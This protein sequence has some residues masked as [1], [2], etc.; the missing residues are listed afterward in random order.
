MWNCLLN[1]GCIQITKTDGKYFGLVR[2]VVVHQLERHLQMQ[3]VNVEFGGFALDEPDLQDVGVDDPVGPFLD[4]PED[5]IR[6]IIEDVATV[7]VEEFLYVG[8]FGHGDHLEVFDA[9]K[10]HEEPFVY[11]LIKQATVEVIALQNPGVV[12][13]G[14]AEE[15]IAKLVDIVVGD[16]VAKVDA[17]DDTPQFGI[18]M[19]SVVNP[20][21]D[22][23]VDGKKQ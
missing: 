20:Q 16:G 7:T 5:F 9:A 21:H 23:K 8:D 14:P 22:G 12:D 6:V 17:A 18:K 4:D 13:D 3:Q 15:I 1:P 10:V 2:I 19:K 11:I